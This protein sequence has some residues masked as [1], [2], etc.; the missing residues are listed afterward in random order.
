MDSN[1]ETLLFQTSVR[2][3]LKVSILARMNEI[4]DELML[5]F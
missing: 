5:F 4:K 2:W 3:L 1:Y